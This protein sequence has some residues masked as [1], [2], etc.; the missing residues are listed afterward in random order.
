MVEPLKGYKI[1]SSDV[2]TVKNEFD[3]HE[4]FLCEKYQNNEG[5]VIFTLE[6]YIKITCKEPS[7]SFE[8]FNYKVNN[9]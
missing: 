3:I 7:K 2:V 1:I 8:P 9:A 6:P 5:D 4:D